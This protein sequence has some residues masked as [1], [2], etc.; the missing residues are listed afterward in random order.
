MCPATRWTLGFNTFWWEGLDK[1]KTLHA[2]ISSVVE[3]G[4]DAIEFK[5]DSFGPHPAKK[6]IVRASRAARD[7]GLIVSNLVILRPLAQPGKAEPS[8]SEVAEAI[9]ICAAAEIGALNFSSGAPAG[10]PA[11]TPDEWWNPATRPDPAAWDALIGSL[12]ALTKVADAEG[13]DLA[14]EAVVGQL[15][16]DFGS[17]MELLARC[18]HPRMKLTFDPSHYVLAGQDVGVAI[19]RFG[20][21]IRHV[22]LKDAVGRAG[23][24]GKDFIFPVLGE[25]STD[26]AVFFAALRDIGYAG[27]LSVEFE[28]FRFMD[29][30][31]H[32]D[33]VPAQKLSKQAADALMGRYGNE[34]SNT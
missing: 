15:V 22:H 28:S 18:D 11:S 4:Y 32:G 16:C 17:T 5:V 34:G 12:E 6:A 19:R 30:V 14:L 3:A 8:V 21:R 27:V 29:L 9:R 33:P 1:A 23:A 13:V 26:W 25:G 7:A 24:F 20:P 31:W 2:C 10:V